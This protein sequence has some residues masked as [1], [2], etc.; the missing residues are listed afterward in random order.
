[1]FPSFVHSK[2]LFYIS[3]SIIIILIASQISS[4][5]HSYGTLLSYSGA[6]IFVAALTHRWERSISYMI[7]AVI[8]TVIIMI[9]MILNNLLGETYR[10][11]FLDDIREFLFFMSV[12]L[13]PFGIVIG[14]T[15]CCLLSDKPGKSN[16]K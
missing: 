11:T 6:I 12:Y 9:S 5:S 8:S 10:D 16:L 14:I 1:M 3:L 7:L 2:A 13:C 15:G 4:T